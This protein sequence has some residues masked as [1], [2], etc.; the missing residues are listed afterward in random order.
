M[1]N[2]NNV[3]KKSRGLSS[4]FWILNVGVIWYVINECNDGSFQPPG[5]VLWITASISM[6][7]M[8]EEIF[9]ALQFSLADDAKEIAILFL[10]VLM[11]WYVSNVM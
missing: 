10:N 7:F 5:S 4:E 2:Y 8:M 1:A 3:W 9:T 11:L 6:S